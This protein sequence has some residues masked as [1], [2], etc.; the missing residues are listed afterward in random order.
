MSSTVRGKSNPLPVVCVDRP[1]G[2]YWR[3]WDG[4]MRDVLV[5]RG[6]ISMIYAKTSATVERV[7]EAYRSAYPAAQTPWVRLRPG[8][9]PQLKDVVGTNVCD[10]GW[11]HDPALGYLIIGSALDNLTKGAAGQAIQNL[12]VMYGWPETAGLQ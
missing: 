1:G 8:A 6:L 5:A 4:Y 11:V 12:N 7:C 9:L 10:I 2:D 3:T